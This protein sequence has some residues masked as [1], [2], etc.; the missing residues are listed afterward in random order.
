MK[1]MRYGDFY[2]PEDMSATLPEADQEEEFSPRFIARYVDAAKQIH[3]R[4]KQAG[5]VV[6]MYPVDEPREHNINRWNRNLADTLRYCE[7]IRNNIPDALIW[8]DPMRHEEGGVDY[9]PLLDAVD[10]ISTHPCSKSGVALKDPK[11]VLSRPF[12]EV[13]AAAVVDYR[14]IFALRKRIA[15]AKVAGRAT[16]EVAAAEK[17]L[18]KLLSNTA[19]YPTRKDYAEG[20]GRPR[21]KIAGKALNQWRDI[22]AGHIQAIDSARREHGQPVQNQLDSAGKRAVP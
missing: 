10:I 16:R 18:A 19:P 15:R 21:L 6:C 3:E 14:Y 17:S 4:F 22:L 5:L 2:E 20:R 7:I 12:Y 8:V 13:F 9:L 1:E 11:G